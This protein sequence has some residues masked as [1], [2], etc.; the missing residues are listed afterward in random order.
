MTNNPNRVARSR[1]ASLWGRHHDRVWVLVL[2]RAISVPVL[3]PAFTVGTYWFFRYFATAACPG[4][5]VERANRE[6]TPR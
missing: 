6:A 3:L 4:A 5:P 2:G 1:P